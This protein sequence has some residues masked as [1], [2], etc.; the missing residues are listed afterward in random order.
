LPGKAFP[1][2]R[3]AFMLHCGSRSDDT[4][5]HRGLRET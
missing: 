3:A 4:C 2:G 1:G 5:H